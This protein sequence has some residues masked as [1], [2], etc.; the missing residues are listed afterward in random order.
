MAWREDGMREGER[1]VAS[2]S[3]EEAGART[4]Y[5]RAWTCHHMCA[6]CDRR[7]HATRSVTRSVSPAV[8][9]TRC[10]AVRTVLRKVSGRDTRADGCQYFFVSRARPRRPARLGPAARILVYTTRRSRVL[11]T[12]ISITHYVYRL[13]VPKRAP[14][15]VPARAARSRH[16]CALP[17]TACYTYFL[18]RSRCQ[19]VNEG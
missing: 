1:G 10:V 2:R 8:Q 9:F 3:S 7:R 6:V 12:T 11:D 16:H 14:W 5:V 17:S 15:G 13:L 18:L 4:L 19:S